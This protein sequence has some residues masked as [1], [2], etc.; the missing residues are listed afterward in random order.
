MTRFS[1]AASTTSLVISPSSLIYKMRSIWVKRRWIRRKLPPVMR[2]IAA[3]VSVSVKSCGASA[4]PSRSHVCARMWRISSGE[5]VRYQTQPN[6]VSPIKNVP[7]AEKASHRSSTDAYDG[8]SSIVFSATTMLL[9]GDTSFGLIWS[10]EKGV[11]D[12]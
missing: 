11:T 12:T 6:E 8:L 5:S 9:F 3:I 2:A 7:V 10:F 4:R 1:R